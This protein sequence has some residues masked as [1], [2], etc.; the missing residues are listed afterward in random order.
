MEESPELL[1]KSVGGLADFDFSLCERNH[2]LKRQMDGEGFGKQF[3]NMT[4][5]T[6][7]GTTIV[8][9]IFQDGVVLGGDSRSTQGN[10]IANKRSMKVHYLTDKIYASGAGGAADLEKVSQIV[11]AELRLFELNSGLQARVV[12]AVRRLR[13]YLFKYMGHVSCYYLVGG[14]DPTGS[15]LFTVKANGNALRKAVE[16]EGSGSYCAVA[17]LENGFKPNMTE[18]EC[19]GLVKKGL[20]AGMRGDNMSGNSYN[21]MVITAKG[22]KKELGIKPSFAKEEK[23]ENKFK[24][25]A[26]SLTVLSKRVQAAL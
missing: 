20:E 9:A 2:A 16:A 25:N 19:V 21:I 14:V 17:E 3:E 1:N 24:F 11:S 4:K 10:I 5:M 12:M 23:I 22:L 6:S 15:H 18:G 26:E 8:G 13:Q 7:S